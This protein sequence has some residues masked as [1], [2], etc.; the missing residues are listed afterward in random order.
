MT[1]RQ[2]SQPRQGRPLPP[3]RPRPNVTVAQSSRDY[4]RIFPGQVDAMG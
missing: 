1:E 4:D 3:S 2:P